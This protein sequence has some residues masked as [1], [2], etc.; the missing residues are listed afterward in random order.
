MTK[1]TMVAEIAAKDADLEKVAEA[2]LEIGLE[3][4][5]DE[6]ASGFLEG[7]EIRNGVLH[8]SR[9]AVASDLLHE[10]G[11]LAIMPPIIR[12]QVTGDV[13]DA[14]HAVDAIYEAHRGND[15]F[16][17]SPLM[18]ALLQMSDTEATAWAYAFGLRCGLA[19]DQIIR[20]STYDGAGD[21][22]RLMLGMNCYLGIHGLKAAGFIENTKQFPE[23]RKWLQ[24]AT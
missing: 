9:S 13:E 20:G 21:E 16:L 4:V 12:R 3:V 11:H 24:D 15:A 7:I 1:A 10:A 2:L 22:I 23:L 6:S 18:R 17:E 19:P 14:A 5:W 8:V